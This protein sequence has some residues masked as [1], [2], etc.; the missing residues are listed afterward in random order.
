M[1][2]V[3]IS[4]V[5]MMV[6]MVMI[7]SLRVKWLPLPCPV[8]ENSVDCSTPEKFSRYLEHQQ[9]IHN[10]HW[11]APTSTPPPL[12]SSSS[13]S[14]PLSWSW[15]PLTWWSK[16]GRRWFQPGKKQSAAVV[17]M[18]LKNLSS[19]FRGAQFWEWWTSPLCET[20]FKHCRCKVDIWCN[21][22]LCKF[23]AGVLFLPEKDA[24]Y[25]FLEETNKAK[26]SF[27]LKYT[28]LCKRFDCYLFMHVTFDQSQ[29]LLLLAL[30]SIYSVLR[31]IWFTLSFGVKFFTQILRLCKL[32]D[33]YHVCA[34]ALI[35][36]TV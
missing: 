5:F 14:P 27:L 34:G 19:G 29:W 28:S 25:C 11:T 7:M 13:P 17:S 23:F 26:S 16:A 35:V 3:R 31:R 8:P 6:R 32:F 4:L 20:F 10:Y 9:F 33:K 36:I 2:M 30:E 1:V 24:I 21:W 12:W 18:L 15:N 22:R